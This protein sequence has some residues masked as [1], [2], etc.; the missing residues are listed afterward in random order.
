MESIRE[1]K[2]F[3]AGGEKST[4]EWGLSDERLLASCRSPKLQRSHALLTEQ[5][6]ARS[7]SQI[8]KGTEVDLASFDR[9]EQLLEELRPESPLRL[10]LTLELEE[11]RNMHAG[12][13]SVA[14]QH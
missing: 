6:V 9:A 1:P 13:L 14:A 5:E 8:F 4:I 10:R 7:W 11:L 3:A 12:R 2:S